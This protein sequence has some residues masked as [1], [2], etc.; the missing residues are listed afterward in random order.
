MLIV[1][2][3]LRVSLLSPEGEQPA[4]GALLTAFVKICKKKFCC[5]VVKET[6]FHRFS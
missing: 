5:I 3:H 1:F 2:S 4:Q 6:T